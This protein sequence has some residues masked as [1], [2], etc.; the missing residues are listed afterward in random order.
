MTNAFKTVLRNPGAVAPS[1]NPT[2]NTDAVDRAVYALGTSSPASPSHV[3]AYLRA[4]K[5]AATIPLSS[6]IVDRLGNPI[7]VGTYASSATKNASDSNFNGLP[8]ID[9]SPL[10]GLGSGNNSCMQLAGG[11]RLNGSLTTMPASFTVAASVRVN[12]SPPSVHNFCGSSDG[13]WGYFDSSGN[14]Q[15]RPDGTHGI[16]LASLLPA[17]TTSVVWYSWDNSTYV[18]RGGRNSSTVS[19]S[20][21]GSYAYSPT[22]GDH[23]QPFGYTAL[24]SGNSFFGQFEGWLLLDKA[25]MNGSVP[26][27]DALFT[28]LISTWAAS[29]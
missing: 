2:Y 23:I 29:I 19:V 6:E 22:P 18:L 20:A 7:T 24:N 1:G 25:Y 15:F 10:N 12:A 26:A 5:F 8:S 17:T 9:L 14:L 16:T 3:L 4:K 13:L 21:M 11:Y 27:D 28:T